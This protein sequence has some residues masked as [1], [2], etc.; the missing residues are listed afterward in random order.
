MISA[1]REGS[2]GLFS[3]CPLWGISSAVRG[4]HWSTPGGS[5]TPLSGLRDILLGTGSWLRASSAP[6]KALASPGDAW[7]IHQIIYHPSSE[8]AVCLK[9]RY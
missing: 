6:P 3:G 8:E 4:G 1:S 5:S 9:L 2:E 7:I